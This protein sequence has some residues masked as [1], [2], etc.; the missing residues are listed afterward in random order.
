[1]TPD[2]RVFVSARHFTSSDP[3]GQWPRAKQLALGN[4]RRTKP[5]KNTP[6]GLSHNRGWESVLEYIVPLALAPNEIDKIL[7]RAATL[8]ISFF[9][10]AATGPFIPIESISFDGRPTFVRLDLRNPIIEIGRTW[11]GHTGQR[12][13]REVCSPCRYKSRRSTSCAASRSVGAT[14][15]KSSLNIAGKNRL[16]DIRRNS[17][18]Q[19]EEK[20]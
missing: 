1:M 14:F 6:E 2:R 18:P 3:R 15:R 20:R 10:V 16:G 4:T 9:S 17:P 5:R 8:P 13:C 7:V 12:T 19:K 11:L